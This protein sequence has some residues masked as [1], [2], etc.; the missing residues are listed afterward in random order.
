[1]AYDE[2]RDAFLRSQGLRV[3]R[4]WNADVLS[5]LGN[6]T[7]TIFEALHRHEMEG[8]FD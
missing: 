4:F 6:V 7:E 1:M 5:H 8:R 2:R 3:L